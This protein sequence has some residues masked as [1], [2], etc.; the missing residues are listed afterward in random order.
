M[1]TKLQDRLR[2]HISAETLKNEPLKPIAFGF[3]LIMLT[4]IVVW[5]F[6]YRGNAGLHT[7][8]QQVIAACE[9]KY[10]DKYPDKQ[11]GF[12]GVNAERFGSNQII[13]TGTLAW[14][15]AD[16]HVRTEP[17]NCNVDIGSTPWV[18][19]VH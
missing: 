7:Q 2:R 11:I 13:V 4:L 10:K 15:E 3:A 18:W 14:T 12:Q 5:F 6:W 1:S 16:G 17:V 8:E 19:Q 9:G